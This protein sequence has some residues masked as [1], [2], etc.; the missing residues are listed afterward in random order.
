MMFPRQENGFDCGVFVALMA[1]HYLFGC[2]WNS[3]LTSEERRAF[4]KSAIENKKVDL[5]GIVYHHCNL[6]PCYCFRHLHTALQ[7]F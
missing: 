2:E 3:T 1:Y 7:C 5:S 4:L 6:L